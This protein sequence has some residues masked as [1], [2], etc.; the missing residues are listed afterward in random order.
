MT[1]QSIARWVS[2]QTGIS[3][4]KM[5]SKSRKREI[6]TARKG[7]IW[8]SRKYTTHTLK[9]IGDFYGG[10][11]HSTIIHSC[12]FVDDYRGFVFDNTFA[13][14]DRYRPEQPAHEFAEDEFLADIAL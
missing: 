9:D 6:V 13:F 12:T 4:E 11:D 7:A 2:N 5:Q 1:L 14:L 8:L 3:V 10:R